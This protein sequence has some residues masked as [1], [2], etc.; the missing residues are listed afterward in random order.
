MGSFNARLGLGLLV[1][2]LLGCA[3]THGCRKASSGPPAVVLQ[4]DQG[5]PVRVLAEVVSRP[6]D[7]ERG[8]MNR[9]T[10][11]EDHGM[12]FIYPG[13]GNLS[14]WMKNTL[15]PLDM[16]FIG[17][18]R[19]IVGVVENTVPLSLESRKVDAPSRYVLEVNGGFF[20]RHGIVLGSAVG[21]EGIAEIPPN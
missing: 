13:E 7:R 12:L 18:N 11:A 21:F 6:E 9:K 5:R 10:L 17:E 19:R 14:F 4:D 2:T 3:A 8:L 15:I 20:R 16:I 1:A